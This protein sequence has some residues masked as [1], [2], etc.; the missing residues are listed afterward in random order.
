MS[1]EEEDLEN[2]GEEGEE[3]EGGESEDEKEE[4][5]E[6]VKEPPPPQ[7]YVPKISP[8]AHV[9][10]INRELDMLNSEVSLLSSEFMM[11]SSS[12]GHKST[13]YN[14]SPTRSMSSSYYNIPP[15]TYSSP[16]RNSGPQA[17]YWNNP[18]HISLSSP[19]KSQPVLY[20]VPNNYSNPAYMNTSN[21]AAP[22]FGGGYSPSRY[23]PSKYGQNNY[24][25]SY[26]QMNAQPAF[27]NTMGY[28]NY[29]PPPQN[30]NDFNY[31]QLLNNIDQVLAGP[32]APAYNPPPAHSPPQEMMYNTFDRESTSVRPNFHMHTQYQPQSMNMDRSSKPP[33]YQRPRS[34][35]QRKTEEITS[36]NDFYNRKPPF[37]RQNI[38]NSITPFKKPTSPL[39]GSPRHSPHFHGGNRSARRAASEFELHDAIHTLFR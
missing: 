3:G 37:T 7:R 1:D 2:E 6:E 39:R 23:S 27:N 14:V 15:A 29:P 32:A 17:Q 8:L 28:S 34:Y 4:I 20:N 35:S 13:Y 31:G 10:N 12:M 25:P 9:Q 16:I 30:N 22:S 24:S 26:T 33:L 38:N 19:V 18:N 21:Y 11:F 36:M 5:K